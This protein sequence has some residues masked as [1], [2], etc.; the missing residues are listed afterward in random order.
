MKVLLDHDPFRT[1]P[2]DDLDNVD[3]WHTGRWPVRWI[4]H[5]A[6]PTP[7][8]VSA[9]RCVFEAE[10]ST[11][12]RIHVTADERYRLYLDGQPIGRGPERGDRRNW[13][14]ESYDLQLS[15]GSHCLHALVWALGELAPLAQFSLRPGF[16]LASEDPAWNGRLGTGVAHWET[17]LLNGY[18]FTRNAVGFGVGC[19]FDLGQG[20]LPGDAG[21]EERVTWVEAAAGPEAVS[22]GAYDQHGV[23]GLLHWLRPALLPAM[24]EQSWSRGRVRYVAAGPT[25]GYLRPQAA[26]DLAAEHAAW[27]GMLAEEGEVT[28]PPHTVRRVLIDLDDYVCAYPRLVTQGGS[29]AEIRMG[30]AESLYE[31]DVTEWWHTFH[32]TKGHRD[33][34]W[35]KV[36]ATDYDVFHQ[37]GEASRVFEP[38]WWRAG[39]YVELR[40]RTADEP[41]TLT[42]L[43]FHET[44]Y[45]LT[46]TATFQAS[47]ERFSH[48]WPLMVRALQMCSHET[49][50]D[51]P[52]YEQLMYVG[53]SRLEILA[54]YCLTHD[55]R[56]PRKAI[57]LFNA[58]RFPS[59]LTQARYPCRATQFIPP[60]S[61]WWCGMVHDYAL[62]R[63]DRDFVAAMMPGVRAVLDAYLSYRNAE[64]L[65][66]G[67]PGWNYTDWTGAP[68]WHI[69]TP[70]DGEKGA[71]AILTWQLALILTQVA[72]LEVWL[73]EKENAA[74]W[75]RYATA[76]AH[77]AQ[78]AF[79]DEGRALFADDLNHQHFSEHA[80]CL[81]LLSGL[82]EPAQ[83][84]QVGQG[85][86][87][88]PDLTRATIYFSHYLFE[89]YARLREATPLFARLGEWFE[90]PA[91]GFKTTREAPEPSR[92]DCHA[93]GAHPIYHSYTSILGIRP[94]SFGFKTVEIRPLLGPLQWAEGTLVHPRGEIYARL[95][96]T[97][98]GMWGEIVLPEGVHGRLTL[99]G[100]VHEL[101]PG[102]QQV[103]LERG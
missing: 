99:D 68:G 54:T 8:F 13:F 38:L 10:A 55:D 23:V 90:L 2:P 34:I 95:E 14:F 94:A 31:G 6:S 50:M 26:Q 45:P 48:V 21:W 11:V 3:H 71:S 66:V 25:E 32:A 82:L 9:Y 37:D 27:A 92:S 46:P 78:K 35:G 89:T 77:A 57:E 43:S 93:W 58:S 1:L 75:K 61:L 67:P 79:W 72:G 80:Q 56:L 51:C 64:G 18:Q 7:P 83:A 63:G 85:L 20:V 65:V 97:E 69:G 29:G 33:E 86:I 60:F 102:R 87:T 47:D 91:M 96:R 84:R 39:R 41:L 4:E 100:E 17:A 98:S 103:I 5:P 59:G 15:P 19:F 101:R 81:A 16:L 36:L 30:W 88:D 44:R 12:V 53:D 28:V 24:L 70:P 52:Y 62:W 42:A 22:A 49:Y 73:G 40:V 74:R 76:V